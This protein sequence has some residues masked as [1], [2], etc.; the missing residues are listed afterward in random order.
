MVTKF[1]L[2]NFK[3][4]FIWQKSDIT[5]GHLSKKLTFGILSVNIY[6]A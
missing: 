6:D 4:T 1:E 5:I 2:I 3:E